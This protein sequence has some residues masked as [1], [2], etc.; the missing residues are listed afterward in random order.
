VTA[1]RG[2]YDG[3]EKSAKDKEK[4]SAK[5]KEK[6]CATRQEAETLT[7]ACFFCYLSFF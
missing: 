3:K 7:A 4:N 2:D 5:D 1:P 6:D